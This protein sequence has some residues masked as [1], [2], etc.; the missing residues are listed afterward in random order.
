[1]SI[2]TGGKAIEGES[3]KE[4]IACAD[5]NM[6]TAK[7]S[8]NAFVLEDVT[9]EYLDSSTTVSEYAKPLVLIVDDAEMNHEILEEM[10]KEEYTFLHVYDG[11]EA[12]KVLKENQKDISLVL[13][14][15]VMPKSNRWIRCAGMDA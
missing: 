9:G 5:K 15:L 10:L 12:L 1:M 6:Y 13:L 8:R 3:I 2:S 14:D 7:Q 11:N 4:A